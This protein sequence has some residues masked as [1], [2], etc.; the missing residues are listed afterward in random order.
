MTL[1][2]I[3][4]VVQILC[5]LATTAAA[6]KYFMAPAAD[7]GDGV[8]ICATCIRPGER[9][10]GCRNGRDPFACSRC[11]RPTTGRLVGPP[12]PLVKRIPYG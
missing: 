11:G 6:L 7:D 12:V 10:R 3:R 2:V 4:D 8:A 5:A 9:V 1:A